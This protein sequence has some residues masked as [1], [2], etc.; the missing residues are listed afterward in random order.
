MR[1]AAG[2]SWE[3]FLPVAAEPDG[4]S[5][6]FQPDQPLLIFDPLFARW[7]IDLQNSGVRGETK[8]GPSRRKI[9]WNVSL[10][11]HRAS[12][13]NGRRDDANQFLPLFGEQRWEKHSQTRCA[14]LEYQR[15]LDRVF[16]E[17]V[18]REAEPGWPLRLQQFNPANV[19]SFR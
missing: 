13:T 15:S 6:F 2:A 16:G 3:R 12:I 4:A 19:P 1:T 18:Q 11:I 5:D 14:G 7:Q 10:P 17:P 8:P 9:H